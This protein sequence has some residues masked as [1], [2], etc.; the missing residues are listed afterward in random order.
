[1]FGG[2]E[3][4]LSSVSASPFCPGLKFPY[5]ARRPS[6]TS[7]IGQGAEVTPKQALNLQDATPGETLNLLS[8]SP[9]L[10]QYYAQLASSAALMTQL[11]HTWN[12][13]TFNPYILQRQA[14]PSLLVNTCK[15]VTDD[16]GDDVVTKNSPDFLQ[17][18]ELPGHLKFCA[19]SD[20]TSKFSKE[21]KHSVNCNDQFVANLPR[22]GES[23]FEPKSAAYPSKA[24]LPWYSRNPLSLYLPSPTSLTT[25]TSS[26]TN[27][28]LLHPFP[29]F[30]PTVPTQFKL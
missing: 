22:F 24:L 28:S 5:T 30:P 6:F 20:E 25:P 7:S 18:D 10:D 12:L 19:V 29:L 23:A 4:L 13:R 2:Q 8:R 14:S 16:A 17:K 1:M 15:N 3:T 9:S 11:Q 21:R 27:P 26:F